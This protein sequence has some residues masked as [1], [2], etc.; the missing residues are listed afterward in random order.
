MNP[1]T[2]LLIAKNPK[3]V[4]AGQATGHLG[5]RPAHSTTS[6]TIYASLGFTSDEWRKLD[7]LAAEAKLTR[8]RYIASA[9]KLGE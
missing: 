5:G 8:S 7:E 4:A 6:P 3:R 1:L 9:L 2:K